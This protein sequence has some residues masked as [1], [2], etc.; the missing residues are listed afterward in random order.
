M[1]VFRE[2]AELVDLLVLPLL[3]RVVLF[4]LVPVSLV[5]LFAPRACACSTKAAAYR[6]AM[7][8][9][10]RN[11]IVAQDQ[12]FDEHKRYTRELGQLEFRSS[13]GVV[14][15]SIAI[16]PSG[17]TARASYPG[18]TPEHCRIDYGPEW[19]DESRPSCDSDASRYRAERKLP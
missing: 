18:G 19:N 15:D 13:T 10:L 9:D 5:L 3:G 14:I 2:I 12:Y 4:L 1:R 16:T 8:S 7:K 6:A 11:L 17:F